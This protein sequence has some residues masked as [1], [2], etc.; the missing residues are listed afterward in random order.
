MLDKIKKILNK[1]TPIFLFLLLPFFSSALEIKIQ[2][3]A[4]SKKTLVLAKY[5]D[6]KIKEDVF[7]ALKDL[8]NLKIEVSELNCIDISKNLDVSYY[9]SELILNSGSYIGEVIEK[10]GDKNYKSKKFGITKK[11]T[12][13]KNTIGLTISDIV[14]EKI[15][16]EDSFFQSKLAFVQRKDLD[17]GSKIFN[18]KIGNYKGEESKTLLA[19]TQ[20]ILSIDWSTD[21]KKLAYV[22]YEKVRSSV[23]IH[24]LESKE[25]KR[26]ASFKGINAFPSW[27][28]DDKMLALSLSKD[29]TSDLYIYYLEKKLLKKITNFSYDAT[30]PT[31]ISNERI[32]FTSNKNKIPYLYE[33]NLK[34]KKSKPISRNYLYNTSSKISNDKDS[35]YS[36]Y[37]KKGKSGILETNIDTR[38]EKVIVEDFFAESPSVAK[39][40]NHLI[41][42]TKEKDYSV[43][44]M[45]NLKGDEL[46]KIKTNK[47][48]LKEPSYSN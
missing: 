9:C 12:E 5:D 3:T 47:V 21:N 33:L 41:Y 39:G 26:I 20:P 4:V 28:P 44:K 40:D 45:I 10:F 15:F 19:S 22:S 35:L 6:N 38:K 46:F 25:R 48:H 42:S 30:E 7:K 8:N 34:T 29:G 18:L 31:W 43:L 14:Y 37:S 11:E 24:D 1:K 27:S 23:F 16:N 32:A 2:A 17:N 13:S 36:I